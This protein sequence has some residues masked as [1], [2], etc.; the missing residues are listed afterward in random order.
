M[1]VGLAIRT[2]DF[3][4]RL[5]PASARRTLGVVCGGAKIF[6]G[7]FVTLAL[8]AVGLALMW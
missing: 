4:A 8:Y 2:F 7:I 3:D 5:D 1:T 6:A